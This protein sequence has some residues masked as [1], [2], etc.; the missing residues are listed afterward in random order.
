MN[1]GLVYSIALHLV[2]ML[3]LVF[4]LPFYHFS[5]PSKDYA[6]VID[7]VPITSVTNLKASFKQKGSK[8]KEKSEKQDEKKPL[9]EQK[10]DIAQKIKTNKINNKQDKTITEDNSIEQNKQIDIKEN[11]TELPIKRKNKNDTKKQN[12][13]PNKKSNDRNDNNKK[14]APETNKKNKKDN[15]K[16]E[17]NRVVMKSLE[18]INNIAKEHSKIDKKTKNSKDNKKNTNDDIDNIISG[19]TNKEYHEELPISIS[20]LDAIRSHIE[21]RWNQAY[22]G[23]SYFASENKEAMH[24]KVIISLTID[25]IVKNVTPLLDNGSNQNPLYPKFVDSAIRAVYNA[26]PIKNLPPKSKYSIWSE[27]QL[28]FNSGGSID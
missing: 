5:T 8:I 13:I 12:D 9:I 21:E 14:K 25:G 10:E 4:G 20:E 3:T 7:V 17:W 6:I 19:E 16:Q 26:S 18:A 1:K 22:Y 11:I 24:V 2:L 27:I 28:T 23:A 15:N